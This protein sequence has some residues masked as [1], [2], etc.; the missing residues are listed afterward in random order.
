MQ[1]AYTVTHIRFKPNIAG[2]PLWLRLEKDHGLK[3]N[4]H[5]VCVD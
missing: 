4:K 5:V 3:F 1:G 2:R